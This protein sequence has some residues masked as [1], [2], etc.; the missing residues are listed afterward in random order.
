MKKLFTLLVAVVMGAAGTMFAWD[1]ERVQI[2]DLYYNLDTSNQT[3]EV[4]SENSSYPYWSTAI[5]TADIPSSVIYD[6]VVYSVSSIGNYAFSYC[7]DLTSVTIPNS[8]TSIGFESFYLCSGLTSIE[9][10][11]SVTSIGYEA[12]CVCS[13]LTSV[14]IPNSVTSIEEYAFS[15]CS[16]LIS[17]TIGSSVTNIRNYAFS[18]CQN[19]S[20]VYNN[21]TTPQTIDENVFNNVDISAC[22]LHVPDET[23]EA[24]KE[25]EVWS[26]FIYTDAL[27]FSGTF[28]TEG[29]NL[30]WQLNI[31]T[32]NL[33]IE[34]T[35]AMSSPVPW[36]KYKNHI[37]NVSLPTGLT[38]IGNNAFQ[39][40]SNLSSIDIPSSVKSI[41][42]MAFAQCSSITSVSIPNSVDSLGGGVF[43]ECEN[44]SSVV[45][46]NSISKAGH[47]LFTSCKKLLAPI[48][49]THVFAYMPESYTG[50]Y[51]IPDGI[52]TIAGQAF[53]YCKN[54]TSVIMPNSVTYIGP[55][56]FYDCLNLQNVS[57]GEGL[58][59]IDFGA[60]NSCPFENIILPNSLIN[61]D[62]HDPGLGGPF[63]SCRNLT[64]IIVPNNTTHIGAL[65]F[66]HCTSLES[67]IIGENV[68]WIG[69]QAFVECRSLKSVIIPNKVN[70]IRWGVFEDCSSLR[71]VTIGSNVS[72]IEW[73][74]FKGCSSLDTIYNL[75]STPQTIDNTVFDGVNKSTCILLVPSESLAAYQ[76]ADQ[77]SDFTNIQAIPKTLDI[78]ANEDPLSAGVYYTT[79]YNSTQR[80]VLPDNGTEAYVADLSGGE[81]LL[82]RIAQ[83]SQVLPNNVAVIFRAPSSTITLTETSAA[84]VSFSAENDL[85]GVDAITSLEDLGLTRST[86][87]VLSGN[88][89]DGVGF[90]QC[91]SDN[92]KA[93]KAYLPYAG[94][95]AG[96]PRRMR[97]V[98]GGTTD[99]G[100]LQ[101]DKTQSAKILRNGQLIIIRNGVEYN[102]AGQIVQ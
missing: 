96:A 12:F 98:F 99:V 93:H 87:Y 75:A 63:S 72:T 52:E 46:P 79:F 47:A 31:G 86:C 26:E 74:V 71:S 57:L 33:V 73:E 3:A 16:G 62:G 34:G 85:R 64:E 66:S 97:F 14:T 2:G 21:S 83:G 17:V 60:F 49:N 68:E 56:T 25:T 36:A 51:T 35:G 95:P 8:V 100:Q 92:L 94:A 44:L 22:V 101:S 29:N 4:T 81:L 80:Y 53:I 1:Y 10:P 39:G 61:L 84:G 55:Q 76:V 19:L 30:T 41:G 13:S 67:V 58:I 45:F 11:N 9:I 42:N 18:Y 23:K 65:S 82:T 7:T 59:T 40:C 6:N 54:L 77:W 24:Y 89:T 88:S 43:Y 20:H 32:G 48:Y 28:G 5:T 69:R 91:N 38:H 70:E 37:L 27:I 50:E 90:Y 102:T 78:T 15:E